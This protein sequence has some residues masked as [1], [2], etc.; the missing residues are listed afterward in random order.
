MALIRRELSVLSE[1][2]PEGA[3]DMVIAYMHEYQIHL[4]IKRERKTIL[5]D[6]RPS[7][8]GKPHTI[9]VNAN[10]NQYHFLITFIHELAH[11]LTFLSHKG[12]ASPHGKEWKTC[13]AH[14][15]KKFS[16]K[17]IF[18]EDIRQALNKSLSNL[19]A[20]TCSDP[21]LFK[22]L[23]RYDADNGKIMVDELQPGERFKTEKG[24]VFQ[25][26]EKRR[27]RYACQNIHTKKMYLFPGIFE[28]FKE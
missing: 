25:V 13:F 24:E 27:T 16:D 14:L 15:L 19:A 1:F 2:L 17:H 22:I 12:H 10:L 28:V 21:V 4:K 7:S 11:L 20:T 6:Y 18:P 9:S 3:T 8:N 26:K 23:N 5:G